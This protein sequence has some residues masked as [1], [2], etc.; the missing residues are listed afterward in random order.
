MNITIPKAVKVAYVAVVGAGFLFSAGLI[1]YTAYWNFKLEG[2][3]PGPARAAAK[4]PALPATEHQS[5]HSA[6]T[7]ELGLVRLDSL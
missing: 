1:S 3:L 5:A 4:Q 2:G 7:D 6:A